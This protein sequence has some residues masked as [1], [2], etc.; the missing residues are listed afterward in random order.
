MGNV[1]SVLIVDDDP[2]VQNI[3]CDALQDGGFASNV[4][5]S[6]E[7]AITL[8]HAGQYRVMIIDIGFGSN[9]IKGWSVARRARAVDPTLPVLY[10]T[11]GTTDE[12]TTQGVQTAFFLLNH[13]HRR[14]SWRRLARS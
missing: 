11:G 3:V 12:W 2:V 9:H 14:S 8:L 7:Q 13:L 6:G 1:P 4:A 5:S 10:I